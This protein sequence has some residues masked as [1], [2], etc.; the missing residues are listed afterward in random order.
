VAHSCNPGYSGGRDQKD[1]SSKP[2][3]ENSL[4]DPILKK[5]K[6]HK[7]RAGGVVQGLGPEFKPQYDQEKKNKS[8]KPN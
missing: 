6:S 8:Q 4:G 5:K 3:Q 7:K 2:A 1:C